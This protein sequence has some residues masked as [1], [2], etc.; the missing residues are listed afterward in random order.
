MGLTAD[1]GGDTGPGRYRGSRLIV[2]L[3]VFE[4]ATGPA[5]RGPT[6]IRS[7]SPR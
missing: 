4:D 5:A 6:S 3:Y 2:D 1:P 7:T